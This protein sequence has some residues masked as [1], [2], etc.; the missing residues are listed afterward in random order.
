MA[1]GA[2][3]KL[4]WSEPARCALSDFT[5][6]GSLPHQRNAIM[7]YRTG[8]AYA[9]RFN[10]GSLRQPKRELHRSAQRAKDHAQACL[11]LP[12]GERGLAA[13]RTNAALDAIALCGRG[14]SYAEALDAATA[15]QRRYPEVDPA[16]I[17][18]E[19]CSRAT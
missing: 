5:V 7:V 9:V 18:A 14:A 4:T 2:G 12:I 15:A 1:R 13:R 6:F 17:A 8:H 11:A 3:T 16:A 10:D 19:I